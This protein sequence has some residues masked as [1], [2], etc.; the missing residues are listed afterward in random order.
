[1]IFGPSI[2]LW[3]MCGRGWAVCLALTATATERVRHDIRAS[4]RFDEHAE[5]V[6][7]FDRANLF[8]DLLP[9]QDG[10]QQVLDFVKR[11]PGQSV[12]VYCFSRKQV[13]ELALFLA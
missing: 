2:V 6:A 13:D 3:R 12:I 4:L 7:S 11:Y 9:K 10:V 8:L 1:M 5:F